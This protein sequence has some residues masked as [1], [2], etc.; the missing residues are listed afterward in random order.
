MKSDH[1][2]IGLPDKISVRQSG[3]NLE[4]T[5]TWF[6]GKV[7]FMTAFVIFW[8]GFLVFWYRQAL[9]SDNLMMLLFPLIHVGVGVWLTYHTIAGYLN[10]TY[11]LVRLYRE[12]G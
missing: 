9:G 10:K 6:G 2:D 11:L 8:N 7:L 4:I 3:S 1:V 5:R 12:R